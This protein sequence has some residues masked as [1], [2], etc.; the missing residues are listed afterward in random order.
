MVNF[1][2]FSVGVMGWGKVTGKMAFIL[3]HIGTYYQY[4]LCHQYYVISINVDHY[5]EPS[6]VKIT[7][8][9]VS[10]FLLFNAVVFRSSHSVKPTLG[11]WEAGSLLFWVKQ[12]LEN[13]F[14][15]FGQDSSFFSINLFFV[16]AFVFVSA[17]HKKFP[18]FFFLTG[19]VMQMCCLGYFIFG[20]ENFFNC[21]SKAFDILSPHYGE[22]Y[23]FLKNSML[24]DMRCSRFILHYIYIIHTYIYIV[25]EPAIS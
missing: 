22:I 17:Q 15:S 4:D 16:F 5:H 11:Q 7:H 25:S 19:I 2:R 1:L 6:F 14:N 24:A 18:V 20:Y 13:T 9:R 3:Y 10:C 12:F 8:S 23:M 21:L